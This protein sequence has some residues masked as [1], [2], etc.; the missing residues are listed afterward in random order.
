MFWKDVLRGSGNNPLDLLYNLKEPL[1]AIRPRGLVRTYIKK[2]HPKKR[3][4]CF[5]PPEISYL[6]PYVII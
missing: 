6:Q 3:K 5:Y 2:N 4:L 1:N